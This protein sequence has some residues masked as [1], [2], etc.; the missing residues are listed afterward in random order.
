MKFRLLV[1]VFFVFIYGCTPVWEEEQGFSTIYGK[2]SGENISMKKSAMVVEDF[3][4]VDV[5]SHSLNVRN[6]NKDK[7]GEYLERGNSVSVRFT[8]SGWV[9]IVEGKY[10]GFYIWRGCTSS[11]DIYGCEA[12]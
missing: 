1:I 6:E 5:I 7:T 12:E 11:P 2:S 4:T 3:I 10:T 8:D 9:E